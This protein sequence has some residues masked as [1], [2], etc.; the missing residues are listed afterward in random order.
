LFVR[1]TKR[2]R[3]RTFHGARRDRPEQP[4]EHQDQCHSR[5]Q[6]DHRAQTPIVPLV[7]G[8]S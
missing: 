8:D 2:Q 5:G 7:G 3:R 6:I 4:F 1:K